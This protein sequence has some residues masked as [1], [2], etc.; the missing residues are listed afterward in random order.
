MFTGPLSDRIDC[1]TEKPQRENQKK[2]GKQKPALAITFSRW[3]DDNSNNSQ[4][5][6]EATQVNCP[7][8]P[9]CPDPWIYQ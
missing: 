5:V 9:R 1:I 4:E 6:W 7:I 3:F 8:P 2:S